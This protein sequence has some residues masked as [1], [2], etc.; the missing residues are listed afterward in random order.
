MIGSYLSGADVIRI[1]CG[2]SISRK[3]RAN[4]RDFLRDTR[5]MEIEHDDDKKSESFLF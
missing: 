5:G 3:T 2:G 4:V 1:T